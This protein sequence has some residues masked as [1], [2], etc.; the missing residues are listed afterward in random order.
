[1][2]KQNQPTKKPECEPYRQ[3]SYLMDLFHGTYRSD[4]TNFAGASIPLDVFP[5]PKCLIEELHKSIANNVAGY[6]SSLGTKEIDDL[7]ARLQI[8]S[9]GLEIDELTP[10]QKKYMNSWNEGT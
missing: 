4:Y 3:F 1:M 6:I 9:M 5:N 7:I 10:E 8:N 2:K